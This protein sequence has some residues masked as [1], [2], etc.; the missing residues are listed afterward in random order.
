MSE[1][2]GPISIQLGRNVPLVTLFQDLVVMLRLK[3][4]HMA[5]VGGGGGG[6]VGGGVQVYKI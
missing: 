5:A 2:T 4:K 6:G 3:E 1:T